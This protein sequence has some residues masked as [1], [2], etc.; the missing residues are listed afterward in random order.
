MSLTG[1]ITESYSKTRNGGKI[2]RE[3]SRRSKSKPKVK[4]VVHRPL[5][6]ETSVLPTSA[7]DLYQ[8]F[9]LNKEENESYGLTVVG[10]LGSVSGAVYV[11]RISPHGVCAR[12]G[13]LKVSDQIVN[14]N[15]ENMM[16][17]T[18][19]E[20]IA[21]FKQCTRSINI[22]IVRIPENNMFFRRNKK[23]SSFTKSNLSQ[24]ISV[25]PQS[26]NDEPII[27]EHK[28]LTLI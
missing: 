18:H 10:G 27:L 26:Y 24:L 14:L 23:S 7:E 1:R 15:G 21:V 12:D 16:H 2:P 8:N 11:K 22:G 3:H 28:D 25:N 4:I 17:A 9:T 5:K 13:N 6:K 20:A 19:E